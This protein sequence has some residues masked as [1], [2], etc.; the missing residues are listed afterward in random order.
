[1]R[2]RPPNPFG[3]GG[4]GR[5]GAP[6]APGGGGG[7]CRN[8]QAMAVAIRIA[9]KESD[10]RIGARSDCLGRFDRPSSSAGGFGPPRMDWAEPL[11]QSPNSV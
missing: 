6:I 3:G 1:V 11:G 5:R 2:G 10:E 9:G 8:R 4:R 7:G